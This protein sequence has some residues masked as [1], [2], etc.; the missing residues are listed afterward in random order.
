MLTLIG[1]VLTFIVA[2]PPDALVKIYFHENFIPWTSNRWTLDHVTTNATYE[3]PPN[4][5][6]YPLPW[7]LQWMNPPDSGQMVL[8]I[9]AMYGANY[10]LIELPPAPPGYWTPPPYGV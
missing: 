9:D 3:Y 5:T 10:S 1:N 7:F 2:G 4:P 6:T 8:L